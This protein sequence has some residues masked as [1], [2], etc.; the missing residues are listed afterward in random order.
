LW[1]H[2][3]IDIHIMNIRGTIMS[4]R[5]SIPLTHEYILLGL[6]HKQPMHGYDLHK[7]ITSRQGIAVIWSV[8]QSQLYA[9]LDKL[10]TQGLLTSTLVRGEAHPSR[11]EF[12]L[13]ETGRQAFNAWIQNPVHHPRQ[14]RQ[15]FLARLYFAT[16]TSPEAAAQLIHQQQA[17]CREWLQG[18]QERVQ[19]MREDQ[20]FERSVYDFRATQITGMLAWLSSL[21]KK[22]TQTQPAP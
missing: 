17:T 8:K 18:L 3:T 16:Q 14:M 20:D 10:E 11:K 7:E 22:L 5:P 1:Y 19:G 21:E 9:L 6:L 13:T 15:D 12:Q 2:H 4:P